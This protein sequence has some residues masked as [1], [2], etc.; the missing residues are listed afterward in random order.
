MKVSLS[1]RRVPLGEGVC[2]DSHHSSDNGVQI[3]SWREDLCGKL[4]SFL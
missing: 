4:V 1:I 2:K 3:V